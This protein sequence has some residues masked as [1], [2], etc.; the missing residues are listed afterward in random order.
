MA[1]RRRRSLS[2]SRRDQRQRP[3]R[4][5]LGATRSRCR[6]L[7]APPCGRGNANSRTPRRSR[8]HKAAP[9]LHAVGASFTKPSPSWPR[10]SWRTSGRSRTPARYHTES[11]AS[12]PRFPWRPTGRSRTPALQAGSIWWW[13]EGLPV[14]RSRRRKPSAARMA[15]RGFLRASEAQDGRSERPAMWH[16]Q[17]RAAARG[18][19]QGRF[20]GLGWPKAAP[21]LPSCISVA[22][23][24]AESL[25]ASA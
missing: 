14:P 19:F 1:G 2:F 4:T 12:C 13:S 25:S 3:A 9:H 8:P 23:R 17:P 6:L 15:K 7:R 10:V 18:T 22:I 21:R 24:R 16:G 20:L 11:S 5:T